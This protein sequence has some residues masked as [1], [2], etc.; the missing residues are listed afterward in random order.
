[1]IPGLGGRPSPLRDESMRIV[2]GPSPA[3]AARFARKACDQHD[4]MP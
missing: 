2:V 4:V 1:M 3:S